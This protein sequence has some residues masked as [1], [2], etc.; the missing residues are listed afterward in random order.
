MLG[1]LN[2]LTP[3]SDLHVTSPLQYL[4]T[5]QQ[6]GNEITRTYQL[7]VDIMIYNGN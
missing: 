2:P 5:I 3:R 6:T 7:E 4:Y 1:C